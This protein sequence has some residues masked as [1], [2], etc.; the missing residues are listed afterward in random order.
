MGGKRR[1]AEQANSENKARSEKDARKES[2]AVL[3]RELEAT[4]NGD[5]G[6]PT[7]HVRAGPYPHWGTCFGCG[8]H[9]DPPEGVDNWQPIP[10]VVAAMLAFIEEHKAHVPP[11]GMMGFR[12]RNA[13]LRASGWFFD[14][15]QPE[16]EAGGGYRIKPWRQPAS[17]DPMTFKTIT[18]LDEWLVK[19]FE[20]HNLELLPITVAERP[21][22]KD[23]SKSASAPR[24][25]AASRVPPAASWP[26]SV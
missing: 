18:D 26:P 21:G 20:D 10:V 16:P 24:D 9:L 5:A 8:A 25:Q 4:V 12:M 7:S 11:T 1:K 3:T 17:G 2:E 14:R 13:L 19:H 22:V 15:I 6:G 23:W